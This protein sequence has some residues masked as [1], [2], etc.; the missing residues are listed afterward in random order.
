M[1]R[2]NI[3]KE[4]INSRRSIFPKDYTGNEIP[5]EILA[6]ILDSAHFAPTHKKTKPWRFHVFRRERKQELGKNLAEI[7]R[8]I[9]RPEAFLEKKYQDIYKKTELADT[10]LVICVNFSGLVPEWEEIAATAMAVQNMYL[11]CT[12]NSVGCYWSTPAMKD[13]LSVYLDLEENH[14]CLGFFYMGSLS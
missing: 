13:Y 5:E 6:E 3:L 9:T 8:E 1:D 2:A 10:I 14:R 12:A 7:Y 11:T 4:I